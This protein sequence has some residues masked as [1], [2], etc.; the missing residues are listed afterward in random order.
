[1]GQPF[2]SLP[3]LKKKSLTLVTMVRKT[4]FRT[5]VVGVKTNAVGER[6]TRLNSEYKNKWGFIAK[7]KGR[8]GLGRDGKL[9]RVRG[10][11]AK[12]TELFLKAG[13]V[14]RYHIRN[15]KG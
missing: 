6:E 4:S 15:G 9:L 1:M 8:K 10:I 11:L 5:I 14:I 12:L 13:P 3:L 2:K 7:E